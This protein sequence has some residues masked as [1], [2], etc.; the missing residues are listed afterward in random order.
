MRRYF[1]H[2]NI[3]CKIKEQHSIDRNIAQILA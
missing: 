3:Y 1:L 2:F